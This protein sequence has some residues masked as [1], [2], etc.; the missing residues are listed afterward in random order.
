MC[1]CLKIK[2]SFN[3][4]EFTLKVF[5]ELERMMICPFKEDAKG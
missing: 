4:M 1:I 3:R 2:G 5:L